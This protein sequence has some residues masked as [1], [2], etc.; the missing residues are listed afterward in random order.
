[1]M[2]SK[3]LIGTIE[4]IEY[5]FKQL[6]RSKAVQHT[7]ERKL[8]NKLQELKEALEKTLS[9]PPGPTAPAC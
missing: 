2:I 7:I 6:N 8:R 3:E 4:T 9:Q 5:Y 1:M